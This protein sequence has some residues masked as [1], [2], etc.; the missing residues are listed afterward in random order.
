[1]FGRNSNRKEAE[2][3]SNLNFSS[4]LEDS[5]SYSF[6]NNLLEI[7]LGSQLT[8]LAYDPVQSLLACGTEAGKVFIFGSPG[9]ELS[10]DLG[11]EVKVKHL[12][13]RAGFGFLCVVGKF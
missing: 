3:L 1:M 11:R 7:G 12:V 4:L 9:V 10:F 2:Q 5:N 13:F 8:A 6:G